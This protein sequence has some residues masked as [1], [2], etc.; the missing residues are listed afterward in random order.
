MGAVSKGR[1]ISM[2]WTFL[3]RRSL[4]TRVTFFTL[5]VFVISIG[6]LSFSTSR[7][8]RA[9]IE[10]V[11]G[12]QQASTVSIV[13]AQINQE[14]VDCI[15]ALE[16]V[17]GAIDAS[18]LAKPAALQ[19]LLEDRPILRV[20]FNGGIFVTGVDG[21]AIADFPAV[22]GRVG[23][24]YM[25]RETVAIPLTEGKL[26]IG[27]PNL[28]KTLKAPIFSIAV[29]I[30]D[31]Q[32]RVIGVLVG[33]IDLG[34]HN[35]LNFIGEGRY[36]GGGGY[37]I[38]DPR[39]KLFV[40]A[41]D[42]S[43]VMQ[44]LPAPGIN[45]VLDRRLEGF[46]G[47]AVNLN[48]VGVEVLSSSARI[49]VAGWI[50]IA[51]LPT[52][53]AFAPIR[54]MQA[55]L[56]LVTLLLTLL[57]G[58]LTWWMLRRQLAPILATVKTLALYSHSDQALQPLPLIRQDEIGDLIG[59]FNRLLETLRQREEA[60]RNTE[61]KLRQAQILARS[62]NWFWDLHTDT[63]TWSEE[64]YA[65]YGRDPALHPA[66]YP[67]VKMYF[68]AASWAQ[69]SDAVEKC[70]TNGDS[71]SCDAEVVRP[72]GTKRWVLI[73]GEA[74]RNENGDIVALHG[75]V[76][77]ITD[78]KEA[79]QKITEL[80]RDFVSFLDNTSDFIYFKDANS[81]FRF[82]SQ[83]MANITGHASWRDM[84]GKHDLEVF[85]A[86]TAQIYYQEELPIFRDGKPLL[87]K[88]DPY[89]DASGNKRWVSTNKWP[90]LDANG[91][92]VGLFGISR[93][94]TERRQM[95][96]QVRQM[97]FHDSLTNLPNRRLLNDRLTQ[98]IAAGKRSGC[99]GALMFLDLDN[100]KP[101][102]DAHG[103]EAG[104][105]LLI[106]VAGRL[107]SCVRE[108]DTVARSGGDEFVVILGELDKQKAESITQAGI[109]AEKIRSRLSAPYFLTAKHEGNA[110]VSIEHHCTAS[111]GVA[112]FG[113]HVTNP[114]N[115]LNWADTAMY[116]AK[117]AGSNLI[118][119]YDPQ[120]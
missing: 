50:L 26:V 104:D 56:L 100:F 47:P 30:R 5:A 102:N 59:G 6:V 22:P 4:K 68:A 23:T 32:E 81:R 18:L 12:S 46:D 64:I 9:D 97:A 78:R 101:L 98:A 116:Q 85:P 103:H 28:G 61:G 38:V 93:D 86:E 7:M 80:N 49:P 109:V 54:E 82:C 14:L 27:R 71:Y 88:I 84:I 69:L 99:Y 60:L 37:L 57:A 105:L 72:D 3:Q 110:G 58:I 10:R 29:P 73:Y 36:G 95:E 62:G 112:L 89:Y 19:K 115:I 108:M 35:F 118:R 111:I 1:E 52:A 13:G 48:S 8:L 107:K 41:T 119:F 120:K 66:A 94:I 16:L 2:H 11:L 55:H 77:D 21:T 45:R 15:R 70:R 76:Q 44:P 17:A 113:N 39:Y 83:A 63:H 65:I 34:R 31:K 92:V 79:E 117:G 43:R 75:T 24:N 106:E 90:L 51:T 91:I 40:T 96:E 67:E 42:K 33:T 25:D 87:N 114:D 20:S 53:E 74:R